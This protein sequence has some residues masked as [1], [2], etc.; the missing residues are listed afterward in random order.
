ME[1]VNY[2]KANNSFK[3][4]GLMTSLQRNNDINYNFN[5]LLSTID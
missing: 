4:D 5:S 2:G 3:E 1:L